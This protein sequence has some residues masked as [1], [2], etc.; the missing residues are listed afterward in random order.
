MGAWDH[1]TQGGAFNH[2][3]QPT[4]LGEQWWVLDNVLT[5][6][7]ELGEKKG[8]E[9]QLLRALKEWCPDFPAGTAFASESPDFLIESPEGRRVGL[10]LVEV[11]QAGA[12]SKG[13]PYRE[14]ESA[15]ERVLRRAEEIYYAEYSPAAPVCIRLS[16][17]P[18]SGSERT[19]PLPRPTEELAGEVARLVREGAPRWAG[20]GDLELGPSEFEGT[21]L[22]GVL[23]RLRA[24]ETNYTSP[25][26][27]DSPWLGDISYSRQTA[28]AADLER[29]I[30]IKDRVYEACR[31]GCEE[32]WLVVTLTGGP[33][34]FEDIEEAVLPLHFSSRFDRVVALCPGGKPGRRAVTLVGE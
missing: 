10:E 15:Q 30:S 18:E 23:E 4:P 29:A 12:R 6:S 34:S 11:L 21:P 5:L 31:R 33:A 3:R 32:A 9:L 14:R 16:W 7:R 20:G 22:G 8:K 17:P 19:G 13:S 27:R 24:R 25:Q 28:T 2:Q 26:G 1:E